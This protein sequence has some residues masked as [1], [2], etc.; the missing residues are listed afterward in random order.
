MSGSATFR[1]PP[2]VH[3]GEG[4]HRLVTQEVVRLGARRPLV[5]TDPIVGRL[6]EVREVMAELRRNDL[7]VSVFDGIPSEPTTREVEA[8]LSQLRTTD[9]DLVLAIGGGSCIDTAKAVAI[10]ARNPGAIAGYAG[11]D[12]FP[13]DRLPL[14]AVPT[15]AGTGSEVTRFAI[16]TDPSTSVKMLLS[17]AKL[18]PDVAIVD[19]TFSRSCPP[20]VTAATGIDA[21]THAIEAYVSRRANPTSDLFALAACRL[22]GASLERAWR[23]IREGAEDRPALEAMARGSLCA[24]MAFSNASVALVHGMSRPIGAYFHVPHG[25]SNAML[26]TAVTRFSLE[27]ARERYAQIGR[28]LTGDPAADADA[29]LAFIERVCRV[30]EIPRLSGAGVAPDRLRE[31]APRMASDAIASGSPGNNPRAATP[32]EIVALY[33]ECL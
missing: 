2:V 4:A 8:G 15:T 18:I 1:L 17:D 9:A 14:I 23:G 25:L 33:L 16:V 5:V 20:E 32:E 19:P 3:V 29:A 10:L 22:I 28:E 6:A 7:T 21:L 12:R 27:A 24:G 26:L 13:A 31:L 30:L 11:A